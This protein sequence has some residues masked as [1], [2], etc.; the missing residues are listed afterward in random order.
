MI[1]HI[2][3]TTFLWLC[4]SAIPATAQTCRQALILGLDV[5]LSVNTFDFTLQREGLA[6]ALLDPEVMDAMVGPTGGTIELAVFEWSGQHD[7][8]LLI[9]WTTIDSQQ[10]LKDISEVLIHSPQLERT[11]RTALGA[12][13]RYAR[14]MLRQRSQCVNQT[15]DLSGDGVNN[16]GSLPETVKS[17]MEAAGIIV[18]GLVIQP[19]ISKAHFGGPNAAQ[20]RQYFE[21][22]VIVGPSSFVET[23]IGFENYEEAIRRK[24]LRELAPAI[25]RATPPARNWSTVRTQYKQ[26]ISDISGRDAG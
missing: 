15:L 23:V 8:S 13:M 24:L 16:N 12:A 18:N 14:D 2:I 26:S 1:K 7:Q 10:A 3:K 6:R 5:S 25:V 22:R 9:D 21:D 19:G 17:E 4:L 20:L 11:G